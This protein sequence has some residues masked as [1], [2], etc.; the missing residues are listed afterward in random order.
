[1]IG[2]KWKGVAELIG[3][4]AIVASLIFVG[5]Q[6]RQDKQIA[7]AQVAVESDS[8]VYELSQLISENGDIWLRGL[9][10][11]QLSESDELVFKILANAVHRRHL[12]IY[13]RV[14]RLGTG[15]RENRAAIYAYHI[16]QYPSLRSQFLEQKRLNDMRR[17]ASGTQDSGGFDEL[18]SAALGKYDREKPPV[19]ERTFIVF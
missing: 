11:E 13:A 1:M 12:G 2:D 19:P 18:V 8:G 7:A 9:K 15:T 17:S 5:L 6:L 16:Y 14:P 10:G 3:M 4:T